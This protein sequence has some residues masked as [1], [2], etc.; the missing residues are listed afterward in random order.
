MATAAS[1][2]VPP[3][4][5]SSANAPARSARFG[6]AVGYVLRGVA[7]YAAVLFALYL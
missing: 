3:N 5:A 2:A 1:H 6:M 4:A 7:V